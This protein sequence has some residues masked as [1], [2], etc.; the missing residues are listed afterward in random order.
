M[1]R[2]LAA[3]LCTF[4]RWLYRPLAWIYDGVAAIVSLGMWNQWVRS[5]LPYVHGR[6]VLELGFGPGHLQRRLHAMGVET[7]GLDASPQMC[8]LAA[9]RLQRQGY[10]PRLVNGYAQHIPFPA[11][12]FHQAVATFPTE[13]IFHPATLS[14]VHRVL[15]PDGELLILPVAWITG[16]GLLHRAAATLFRVTGQAPH[17]DDALLQ[18]LRRAG[19]QTEALSLEGKH[20]RAALIRATKPR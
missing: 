16:E 4:F 18:P 11:N 12:A 7:F 13:Y 15:R 17:W 2:L 3:L 1:N 5:V 20:W 19:F 6:R 10:I 8:H 14:E 9:R